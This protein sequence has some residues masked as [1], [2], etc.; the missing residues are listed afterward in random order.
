MVISWGL[1]ERAFELI[2]AR[3]G[4]MESILSAG[5]IDVREGLAHAVEKQKYKDLREAV[6]FT[7]KSYRW[8]FHDK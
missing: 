2:L 4:T 7:V 5:E 8:G 6:R 1:S 3:E